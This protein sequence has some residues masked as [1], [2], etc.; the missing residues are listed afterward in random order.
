MRTYKLDKALESVDLASLE[1][2]ADDSNAAVLRVKSLVEANQKFWEA[3]VTGA[4]GLTAKEELKNGD[5][6][7]GEVVEVDD[8]KAIVKFEGRN[9]TVPFKTPEK[10]AAKLCILL[11]EKSL[12]PGSPQANLCVGAYL[13]SAPAPNADREL[14]RTKLHGAEANAA[15]PL[16][17]ELD[18]QAN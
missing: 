10:A 3:V 17:A 14:A 2:T 11:A 4:K 8:N 13:M 18:A 9:Q 15:A 7:I 12:G 16:L 1:A 5:E 6:V